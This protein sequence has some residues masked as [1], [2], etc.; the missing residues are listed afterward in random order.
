MVVIGLVGGYLLVGGWIASRS[1]M[2][3]L[4]IGG[5]AGMTFQARAPKGPFDIG[6]R[7]DPEAALGLAFQDVMIKTDLGDAP[8][9]FVPGAAD[10]R[11]W[12]IYVHGIGGR[13][14]NGYKYLSVLHEAG[15]PTLIITYRNDEGA[16][17]APNGIYAFG[18]DEW[19]DL[20]AAVA[21]LRA[22]G[23]ENIL[24]GAESMGGG[25]VGQFLMQSRQAQHVKA[26]VLDAPAL[27]FPEVVTDLAQKLGY[28]LA[29]QVTGVALWFVSLQQAISLKQAVSIGV[30]EAFPGPL[31]LSHGANDSVVPVAISD[32]LVTTRFGA[33]TYLRTHADHVQSWAEDPE[34]Y[35]TQLRAF[36]STLD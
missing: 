7:G 23:A 15:I 1:I 14:E 21:F 9:W 32:R 5:T 36:L 11:I 30:I 29:A 3:I 26:L 25:I 16:P 6:Y 34:R 4:T 27:D 2:R 28:P 12:A 31:F 20:D 8:A 17:A 35:R 19:H 18:L 22:Q 24:L 33:T 13:R 10:A